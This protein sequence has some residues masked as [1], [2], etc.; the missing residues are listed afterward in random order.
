MKRLTILALLV[1]SMLLSMPAAQAEAKDKLTKTEAKALMSEML[2][3]QDIAI[4]VKEIIP[5]PIDGLWSF[6]VTI[7]GQPFVIYTDAK[8]E[9]V[10]LPPKGLQSYLLNPRTGQ[11]FTRDTL[12]D[13]GKV[14]FSSIPLDDAIILGDKKAAIK[15]AVFDD[16]Y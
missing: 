10:I 3:G 2:K 15:V 1:L 9:N 5:T 16:P 6:T 14:D 12:D 8:G 7:Q 4:H 13:M 11:V